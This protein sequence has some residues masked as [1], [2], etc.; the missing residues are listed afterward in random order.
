M[1]QFL[2]VSI[3]CDVRSHRWWSFRSLVWV[4]K[5]V[6]PH[7]Y[8]SFFISWNT[9]IKRN[10]LLLTSWLPWGIGI[11]KACQMLDFFPLPSFQNELTPYHAPKVNEMNSFWSIVALNM[12]LN[13]FDMLLPQELSALML[14]SFPH[15]PVS[16]RLS[17]RAHQS[18][19][20]EQE[21]RLTV[22]GHGV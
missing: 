4:C 15:W 9:S 5:M 12:D 8:H 20:A 17:K 13:V 2:V 1:T 14:K 3:L 18:P 22:A 6:L 10:F 16:G 21:P 7:L 19:C 11:G